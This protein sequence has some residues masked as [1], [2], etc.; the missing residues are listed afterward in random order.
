MSPTPED[1]S[2]NAHQ[3]RI[4]KLRAELKDWEHAFAK[5]HDGRKP[6]RE[7]TKKD[8]EIGRIMQSFFENAQS[9]ILFTASCKI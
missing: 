7:E 4:T 6:T 2:P 9:L 1:T 3:E 5:T 8:K